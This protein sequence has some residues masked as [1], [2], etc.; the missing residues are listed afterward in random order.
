MNKSIFLNVSLVF[1]VVTLI[2]NVSG[3]VGNVNYNTG[4]LEFSQTLHTV[5][6][7]NTTLPINLNY[8]SYLTKERL[9]S[10]VGDGFDL[11]MPYIERT[12]VGA[13]DDAGGSSIPMNDGQP[14]PAMG[15]EI[16]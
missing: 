2:S 4:Q 1:I 7:H 15:F 8:H 10:W 9:L 13:P 12:V 14:L 6:G 3:G 5:K 11:D 16:C